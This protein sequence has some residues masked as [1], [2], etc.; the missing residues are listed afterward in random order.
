MVLILIDFTAGVEL[1]LGVVVGVALDT[2]GADFDEVAGTFAGRLDNLSDTVLGDM[3]DTES[4]EESTC[5][6]G[7]VHVQLPSLSM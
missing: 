3:G 4:T 2:E 6:R 5:N 7:Y 1:D